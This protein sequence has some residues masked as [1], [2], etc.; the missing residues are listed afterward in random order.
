MDSSV[1]CA[2]P[3]MQLMIT[4]A[5]EYKICCFSGDHTIG[6]HGFCLDENG[7][8]MN[9]LTHSMD[10]ALNSETSKSIRAAQLN[11]ERH[12]ACWVCWTKDDNVA[13]YTDV[14]T[15]SLRVA[16]T[17]HQLPAA[18]VDTL[19][20]SVINSPMKIRSLD[21]RFT[22][23]CN[24]KCIMCGPMYSNMWYDDYASIYNTDE[25]GDS[26]TRYKIIKINGVS[27]VEM[28]R[29][30]DTEIWKDRFNVVKQDL[31]HLYMTGGEPFLIK[32]HQEILNDL[33]DSDL[34]KNVTLQ[35]DTNLTVI[36]PKILDRLTKFKRVILNVS[37]D[38]IG[39]RYNYIR[40]PGDFNTLVDNLKF[41]F[42][43]KSDNITIGHVSS[44]IGILNIFAPFRFNAFLKEHKFDTVDHFR[45]LRQPDHFDP[46]FLPKQLKEAVIRAYAKADF[47]HRKSLV[48]AHLENN[49]DMD[50]EQCIRKVKEHIAFLNKLDVLRGID[51][52][53][54]FPETATL[55]KDYL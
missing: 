49:M 43:N 24:L 14:E 5:G 8:P 2:L 38:D 20:E 27:K 12:K 18:G 17:I 16:R 1:Y 26:D 29:W 44:C 52:K 40:F 21:L 50:E 53:K 13:K 33:I 48:V 25:F 3:W 41:L 28:P 36:N 32:G 39:K 31:R 55:L 30:H 4:P 34:A 51:W 46:R 11:G 47:D 23:T 15:R 45:M 7:K 54:T 35:Y 10:E 9:V 6:S 42:L 37:V 19:P 22:N